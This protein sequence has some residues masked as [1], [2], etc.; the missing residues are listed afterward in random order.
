M[1]Y[2]YAINISKIKCTEQLDFLMCHVSEKRKRQIAKLFFPKDKIRCFFSELVMKYALLKSFDIKLSENDIAYSEF[3]KPY[4]HNQNVRFSISHS[5]DWVI[6]SVGTSEMGVDIEEL[7]KIDF[8]TMYNNFADIERKQTELFDAEKK[9]ERFYRLW[10]LKESYL[11]YL[12]VGLSRSLD[13]F[14]ILIDNEEITLLDDEYKNI[15][16]VFDSFKIDNHHYYSQCCDC[17]EFV[18]GVKEI[19]LDDIIFYLLNGK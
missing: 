18:S 9:A 6:C 19:T 11:K 17:G 13:S 12:G 10:T 1:I 16:V 15:N 2:Q 3:G 8:N 14:A 5:G 4:L 7:K